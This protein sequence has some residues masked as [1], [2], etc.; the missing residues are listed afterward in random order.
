MRLQGSVLAA[1]ITPAS[2]KTVEGEVC[3]RSCMTAIRQV[4][5]AQATAEPDYAA[6]P[7]KIV[8]GINIDAARNNV[9]SIGYPPGDYARR[10]CCI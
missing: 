4:L 6:S 9:I 3:E 2:I 8:P 1:L 10:L 7:L 5:R